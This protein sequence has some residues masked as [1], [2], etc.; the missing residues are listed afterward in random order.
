M[1][2]NLHVLMSVNCEQL[3][4]CLSRV[5]F[6]LQRYKLLQVLPA[7]NDNSSGKKTYLGNMVSTYAK[8]LYDS[9][10]CCPATSQIHSV[11]IHENC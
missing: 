1:I 4:E 10:T 5:V 7:D 3:Q 9:T 11:H 8:S 2:Y 6:T